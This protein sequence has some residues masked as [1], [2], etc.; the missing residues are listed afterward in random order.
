MTTTAQHRTRARDL[1]S[2]CRWA[3]AADAWSAAVAAY[4]Q[5]RAGRLGDLARRDIDQMQQQADACRA[6]AEIEDAD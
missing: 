2:R 5:P 3:E 4:P 6:Q 1:A